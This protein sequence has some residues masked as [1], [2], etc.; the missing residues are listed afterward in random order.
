[1]EIYILNCQKEEDL[2]QRPRDLSRP[3]R[4][5]KPTEECEKG[6]RMSTW[7]PEEDEC[8]TNL[9]LRY[10][11][12]KWAKIAEH[13]PKRNG[14]QCRER[15]HN[16]L[17][18]SI[19]KDPWTEE[20]DKALLDAHAQWGNK[21]AQ[22]ARML[23]GRTD[24]A[25][26]NHWNSGAMKRKLRQYNAE[27][28]IVNSP[29]SQGEDEGEDD[30][31]G[32]G[33]R[34]SSTSSTSSVSKRRSD[35]NDFPSRVEAGGKSNTLKSCK[36]EAGANVK[37]PRTVQPRYHTWS[38]P[39]EPVDG[40]APQPFNAN[41]MVGPPTGNGLSLELDS[42]TNQWS[43][44]L[45]PSPLSTQNKQ[46]PW[47]SEKSWIASPPFPLTVQLPSFVDGCNLPLDS[48]K[49]SDDNISGFLDAGYNDGLSPFNQL[50][51]SLDSPHAMPLESVAPRRARTLPGLAPVQLPSPVTIKMEDMNQQLQQMQ[52]HE[53][54][55]MQQALAERQFQLDWQLR[56][57][58]EQL[59][60]QR[61][62]ASPLNPGYN[63]PAQPSGFAS[64]LDSPNSDY[65][66]GGQGFIPRILIPSSPFLPVTSVQTTPV[67]NSSAPST[68]RDWFRNSPTAY[69]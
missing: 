19:R 68:P 32:G 47:Q 42:P 7:S 45:S 67:L 49:M 8:V 41:L 51:S 66:F 1:M 23:P 38:Y 52:V 14:K 26:K 13:L 33:S 48:D 61:H 37:R 34:R 64:S 24:N 28:G 35:N 31:D 22:I 29:D 43:G 11:P 58:Q 40:V 50:Q 27:R 3:P 46:S 18:P 2:P 30:E 25:I 5:R 63:F 20:E 9:V 16:H 59:K 69:A 54:Q 39:G 44:M 65:E 6:K 55:P 56:M 15:W 36:V 17:D 21:W 62:L 53:P 4:P 60:R 12:K 10:G 57:V